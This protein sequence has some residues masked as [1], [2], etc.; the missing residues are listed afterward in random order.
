LL[1]IHFCSVRRKHLGALCEA[2]ARGFACRCQLRDTLNFSFFVLVH[3]QLCVTTV[4][5][6][7]TGPTRHTRTLAIHR[8]IQAILAILVLVAILAMETMGTLETTE[9]MLAMDYL[10]VTPTLHPL[11]PWHPKHTSLHPVFSVENTKSATV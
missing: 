8:P 5:R 2:S 10:Q 4:A 1:G 11:R 6:T 7:R 3:D 9:T